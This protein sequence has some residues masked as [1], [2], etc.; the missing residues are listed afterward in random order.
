MQNI[1]VHF[2]LPL[3][4]EIEPQPVLADRIGKQRGGSRETAFPT[5][6]VYAEHNEDSP[7]CFTYGNTSVKVIEFH[8]GL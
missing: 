5:P 6:V 4:G 1:H 8:A 7:P 2:G 3:H